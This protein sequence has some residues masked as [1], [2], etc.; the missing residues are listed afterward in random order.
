MYV[1]MDDIY[2][3]AKCPKLVLHNLFRGSTI[4][5][6]VLRLCHA[7]SALEASTS[8]PRSSISFWDLAFTADSSAAQVTIHVHRY[9]CC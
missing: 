2:V 8:V 6:Y 1:C 3:W 5:L 7:G 4:L 9:H